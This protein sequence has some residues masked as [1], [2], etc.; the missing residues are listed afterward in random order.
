MFVDIQLHTFNIASYIKI[1]V[2]T[3][4]DPFINMD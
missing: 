4:G 2:L 1:N 3:P